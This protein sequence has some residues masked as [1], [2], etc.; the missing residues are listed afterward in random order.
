MFLKI[1]DAPLTKVFSRTRC[2]WAA[3][4]ASGR[5]QS[6]RL[7]ISSQIVHQQLDLFL[8]MIKCLVKALPIS[9]QTETLRMALRGMARSRWELANCK[10]LKWQIRTRTRVI[11]KLIG[12]LKRNLNRISWP[13]RTNSQRKISKLTKIWTKLQRKKLSKIR[14]KAHEIITKTW[15]KAMRV[16]I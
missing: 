10:G 14:V 6:E 2:F 15:L 4:H 9:Q 11:W 7:I 5:T 3:V 8:R 12:G 1:A 16:T 13:K